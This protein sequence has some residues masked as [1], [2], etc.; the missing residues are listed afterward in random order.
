MK[1]FGIFVF[2]DSMGIVKAYVEV[3]LK[4]IREALDEL[5][6][7]INGDIQASE[8][9]KLEKYSQRIF[10]RQNI[11]Y[12]G[13][14]YKDAFMDF[15]RDEDWEPWDEIVLFNDTFYGSF[16]PWD[17]VFEV[18]RETECD[19]WGLSSFPGGKVRHLDGRVVSP[20]VQSYFI[21]VRKKMFTDS[22]FRIFWER[23]EY[24]KSLK[25]AIINFEIR[26][27]EYFVQSGFHY[28]SW[29]EIKSESK[30]LSLCDFITKII[31]LRFP[32]LKRKQYHLENYI[33]YEKFFSYLTENTEYPVEAIREDIIQRSETGVVKPYNPVQ[34][35]NF[36][37]RYKRIYLYG[38]GKY[39]A[40]LERYLNDNGIS[41][42]G[43]I[44]TKAENASG[45][46]YIFERF[47]I[48]PDTGIIVA[49]NPNN[50]ED[51]YPELAKRV[52]DE[53]MILPQYD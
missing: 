31:S 6:I 24:S 34:L 49:L 23:L 15:L 10:Q 53:Q 45:R 37:K 47:N 26:F 39:A 20:H 11:G 9:G 21:A 50:F 13:G 19:F 5:V 29:M 2:Y 8:K 18:M 32:I 28:K 3:L 52:S 42:S 25:E 43:Y 33:D 27:S 22:V 40:N 36:C 17:E 7:V 46:V 16:Y 41:V 30:D 12:D 51:V 48:E 38:C 44:V 4:G 35:L 1:R 14:A